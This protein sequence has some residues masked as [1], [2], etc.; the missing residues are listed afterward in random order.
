MIYIYAGWAGKEGHTRGKQPEES[1]NRPQVNAVTGTRLKHT[2][3][4]RHWVTHTRARA[5]FAKDR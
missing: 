1:N 2:R 5:Q 4:P 3:L